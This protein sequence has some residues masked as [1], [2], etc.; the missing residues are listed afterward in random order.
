MLCRSKL[1][2]V[3]QDV[4]SAHISIYGMGKVDILWDLM[5]S[6][7]AKH[8]EGSSTKPWLYLWPSSQRRNAYPAVSVR[9]QRLEE[10]NG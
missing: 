8:Y 10:K 9:A 5:G 6:A 2:F 1:L 3:L 4:E 7:E